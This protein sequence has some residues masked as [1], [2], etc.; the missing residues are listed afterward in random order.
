MIE[1][2]WL[3]CTRRWFYVYW[4]S[5]C[6]THTYIET[7][8]NRLIHKRLCHLIGY[9]LMVR[10]WTITLETIQLNHDFA[11]KCLIASFLNWI[12]MNEKQIIFHQQISCCFHCENPKYVIWPEFMNEISFISNRKSNQKKKKNEVLKSD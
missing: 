6:Y 3:I 10:K 9:F 11:R 12:E 8:R 1:M 7:H 2:K 5:A 4:R